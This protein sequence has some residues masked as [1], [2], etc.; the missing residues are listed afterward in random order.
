MK[1]RKHRLSL[2]LGILSL[3]LG[4]GFS[5]LLLFGPEVLGSFPQWFSTFLDKAGSGIGIGSG[6]LALLSF[7]AFVFVLGFILLIFRKRKRFSM[8]L[9]VPFLIIIYF[10]VMLFSHMRDGN[11]SPQFIMSYLDP[12]RS[13]L[14]LLC[15]ILEV[16]LF[17]TGYY[18]VGFFCN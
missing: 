3:I 18:A 12:E 2:A 17:Q 1:I 13:W 10:T 15:A 5:L 6:T 14:V 16:L 7:S 9:S 11:G 4:G 8:F